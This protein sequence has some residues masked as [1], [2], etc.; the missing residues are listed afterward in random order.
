M[1]NP[2]A[3]TDWNN[4]ERI[5]SISHQHCESQTQ[6]NYLIA[7]GV[8]H[9]AISNYYPSVPCYPPIGNFDITTLP[10]GALSSPNAEHHNMS[11][12]G[13]VEGN[14]HFNSLGCFFESGSERGE[15]PVGCGGAPW[16]N[17]FRQIL[18]S[19]QYDDAGGITINHP[20]WS[21]LKVPMMER[22]LDYDDRVLG[23]EIASQP[24]TVEPSSGTAWNVEE[25]DEILLTGRKCWGFFVA[26]HA[27]QYNANWLGRNIL[28]IKEHTEHECLKAY[29]EGRFYGQ[30]AHTDLTF[31]DISLDGNAFSVTTQNATHIDIIIDGNKTTFDENSASITIPNNAVYVRAEAHS[32]DDS[33]YSNAITFKEYKKKKSEFFMDLITKY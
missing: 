29:R 20:R 6:L 28:L 13:T 12:F 27:G 8:M 19:L 7:G 10:D 14:N 17:I 26:D 16:E 9:Y 22:F 18:E 3:N 23:I 5:M 31:L 21:N 25:W 24:T 2:Y 15:T 4:D 33:I 11:F 1:R 30:L 32:D